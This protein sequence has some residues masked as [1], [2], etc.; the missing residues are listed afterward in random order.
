MAVLFY[1]WRIGQCFEDMFCR[2]NFGIT[3]PRGTYQ[4]KNYPEG[5]EE[6]DSDVPIHFKNRIFE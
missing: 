6:S 5:R 1:L 3:T 4:N 2:G